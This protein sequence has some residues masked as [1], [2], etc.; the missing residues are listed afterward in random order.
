MNKQRNVIQS[1]RLWLIKLD[2]RQRETTMHTVKTDEQ[3]TCAN[4]GTAFVGR[5]CPQ[6]G[7]K[8]DNHRL[9]FKN[10]VQGFLDIWGFGSRPMLRTIRELF[11]RPG[12]MIRDY[13]HGHQPLFFPPFKM[14]IIMTLIFA[15]VASI[16]GV[17]STD[18]VFI[19]GDVFQRY[20]APEWVISVF[21]KIDAVLLW[22]H[23]NPAYS[24]ISAGIFYII[25]SWL[26]FLRRMSFI[27]VFFSQLYISS[28]MQIVGTLWVLITGSEA[29]YNMPPFAV[30]FVIGIPLLCYD[31]S[32]LYE[33]RLWPTIWRTVLTFALMLLLMMLVGGLPIMMVKFL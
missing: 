11:W 15:V 20:G 13:L 16:R 30:P 17:T 21:E 5:F 22:L 23:R 25:A 29:Y 24:A 33:L 4:C 12:Y 10:V 9:T 3:H 28:Q 14:L 6:C 1:V 18:E 31:Y 8:A 26:V 2:Q 27:E 32:Q 19:Y 7:L